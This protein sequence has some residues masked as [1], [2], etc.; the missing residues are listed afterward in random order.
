[1]QV[2]LIESRGNLLAPRSKGYS[3]LELADVSKVGREL[4]LTMFGSQRIEKESNV[5]LVALKSLNAGNLAILPRQL[6]DSGVE[7][8]S[9]QSGKQI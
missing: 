2:E 9:Q 3:F 8:T 6:A 5:W 1:M 7:P 4:I